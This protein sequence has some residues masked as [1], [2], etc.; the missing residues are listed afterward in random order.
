MFVLNIRAFLLLEKL[1]L[2]RYFRQNWLR[3][4]GILLNVAQTV[5]ERC[6]NSVKTCASFNAKNMI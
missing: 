3:I 1:M 2:A 4:Q 5:V 6:S